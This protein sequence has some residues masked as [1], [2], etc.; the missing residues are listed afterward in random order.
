[1][2]GVN[3]VAFANQL[4]GLAALCVVLV[5][6]TVVYQTMRP[7]V[8]WVVAAPDYD[9]PVAPIAHWVMP[10]WFDAGA[11]GVALFFLISGFVIPFSLAGT[12][13][14]RFLAARALRIYPTF[15]AGLTLQYAV[16][17]IGGA[18]WGR[19]IVFGWQVFLANG[20]LVNSLTGGPSVDLVSW[21]LC[22]EVKFYILMA[23]LRPLVLACRVWPLMAVAALAV[24]FT[25]GLGRVLPAELVNEGMYLAFMLAGTLFNYHYR[26]ALRTPGLVVGCLAIASAMGLCWANGPDAVVW[27]AKPAN[28]AYALALFA[29]CYALRSRFGQVRVLDALA[30]ISYP[31]YLVH[32]VLGFM[33]MSFLTTALHLPYPAAAIL[34]LGTA[35]LAATALH[36]TVERASIKAGR[37]LRSPPPLEEGGRVEGCRAS[38]SGVSG[39]LDLRIVPLATPPL[40]PP[41]RGGG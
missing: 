31:L 8:G 11:F 3:R 12:T 38:I 37:A 17:A 30:A 28:Y 39:V 22:I 32:S 20:L 10:P 23:L 16:V 13:R 34:A 18:Y 24:A 40:T 36:C 7:M 14:W 2:A 4:R 41:S 27:P 21:T 29:T 35:G 15:W 6:Y 1:V 5:H 26:A 33:V 25:L 19:P 9:G